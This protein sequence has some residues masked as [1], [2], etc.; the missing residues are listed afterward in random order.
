MMTR[1]DEW[2][3]SKGEIMLDDTACTLPYARRLCC[4]P[5][6]IVLSC[7]WYSFKGGVCYGE[8]LSGYSEVG[9]NKR[10]C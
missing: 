3:H 6:E 10:G 2:R 1:D 7:G 5:S 4:P 9:S 8:C